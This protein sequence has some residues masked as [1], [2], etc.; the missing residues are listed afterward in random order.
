MPSAALASWQG[1]R[2]DRIRQLR[3][4]HDAVR[5]PGP[6]RKWNTEQLNRALVLALAAEFQGFARDL[7]DLAA[8]VF[9]TEAAHGNPTLARVLQRHLTVNRQLS[10][11]NAQPGA[12]GADFGR[13]GLELWDDLAA[14]DQRATAWNRDLSRLNDARNAI[15]HA[16]EARLAALRAAG[17]PITL[18]QF[19]LWRR[20]LDGLA[21]AMDDVTSSHLARLFSVARPW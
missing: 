9:V 7:H 20:A 2:R 3:S 4:V 21:S 17:Y 6:G 1:L 18:R 15:A 8:D 12:L 13:L 5:V 11:G 10:R 19:I 16:E 14:N